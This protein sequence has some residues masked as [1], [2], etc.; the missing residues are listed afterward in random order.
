M[1]H[2]RL[3]AYIMRLLLVMENNPQCQIHRQTKVM[4]TVAPVLPCKRSGKVSELLGNG[5]LLDN[6]LYGR[7][8]KTSTKI[9][10]TGFPSSV[11]TVASKSCMENR[12][13]ARRKKPNTDEAPTAVMTPIGALSAALCVSS[14]MCALIVGIGS[15]ELPSEQRGRTEAA[16]LTRRRIL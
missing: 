9:C 14:D 16:R 15:V 13:E 4:A 11:L 10:K 1:E 2:S 5:T 7:L 12:Y 6:G 8:T 3:N